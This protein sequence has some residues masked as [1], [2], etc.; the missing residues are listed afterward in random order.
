MKTVLNRNKL[1]IVLCLE[2]HWEENGQG[3]LSAQVI[4]NKLL[5]DD[6]GN[7]CLN[8]STG[9]HGILDVIDSLKSELD[10]LANE[11]VL[12][13][14]HNIAL[15]RARFCVISN[16]GVEAAQWATKD[17]E[18]GGSGGVTPLHPKGSP[19]ASAPIKLHR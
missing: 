6:D 12:W 10:S 3:P 17:G 5:I 15:R 8:A 16:D 9:F 13:L 7:V 19:S 4:L 14:A 11:T 18:G 2:P 1:G